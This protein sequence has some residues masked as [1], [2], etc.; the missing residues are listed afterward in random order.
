MSRYHVVICETWPIKWNC[1]E[2]SFTI[3][4]RTVHTIA[5]IEAFVWE[6]VRERMVSP[7]YDE[8]KVKTLED[9]DEYLM[10]DDEWDTLVEVRPPTN[11][12]ISLCPFN[13]LYFDEKGRHTFDVRPA[14]RA[15]I[16]FH[17]RHCKDEDYEEGA[18]DQE[19]VPSK[20][21]ARGQE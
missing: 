6:L 21:R 17:H 12:W 14:L 11:D 7:L 16:E 15:C 10:E 1:D 13:V 5:Q 19:V 8:T 4:T 18:W 9:F 2:P 20:K 3:H